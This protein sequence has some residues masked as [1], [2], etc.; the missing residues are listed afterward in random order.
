MESKLYIE[1]ITLLHKILNCEDA[2][3]ILRLAAFH[4]L[5]NKD[6]EYFFEVL[7]KLKIDEKILFGMKDS[8]KIEFLALMHNNRVEALY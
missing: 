2:H 1:N 3:S 8:L 4:A 7:R 6:I 5:Q